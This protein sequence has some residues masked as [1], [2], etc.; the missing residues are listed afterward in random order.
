[1]LDIC[2]DDAVKVKFDG[3]LMSLLRAHEFVVHRI[4]KNKKFADLRDVKSNFI[5]KDI[6]ILSLEKIK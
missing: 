5:F 3:R 6:S 2:I 4:S 1:M